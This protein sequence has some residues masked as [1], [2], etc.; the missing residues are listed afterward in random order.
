MPSSRL[1]VIACALA[2]LVL[3]ACGSSNRSTSSAPA[4][5]STGSPSSVDAPTG[6]AIRVG[7]ICSCTGPQTSNLSGAEKV[8]QAWADNV[9]LSGGINGHPVKL[10]AVDD[11]ANPATGLQDAKAL[12]EQDRVI[13]IV[14]ENS[15][16]DATWVPWVVK[17]GI[18]VV[19]GQSAEP[20]Q[21]TNPGVFPSGSTLLGAAIGDPAQAQAQGKHNLGVMYCAETPVC[22]QIV[23]LMTGIAKLFGLKV[24]P[25]SIS[26]TAPNYTAPC[27]KMQSAGVDALLVVDNGPIVQRVVAD[28][29]QQGYNPLNVAGLP[30]T[31]STMLKDQHLAGTIGVGPTAN[32]FDASTPAVKEFQDALQKYY[33][34]LLTSNGFAYD[35]FGTWAGG[36]LFEAAAKAAN[37]GPSSTPADVK[38]GLYALKGETLGGLAPPLT[39]TKGKPYFAPCWFTA[40][41]ENGTLVSLNGNKQ[42]C[43]SAAQTA[44]LFKALHLG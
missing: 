31:N 2:A 25:A 38:K 28:C 8:A 22:E 26:A 44:A 41:I 18:P 13:A 40:K 3:S 16:A 33:P 15:D 34:G 17:Q 23:P 29:A 12:V 39:Y 4:A 32:P 5:G 24:T 30:A 42:T 6:A 10:F 19:G 21:G 11:G 37:L 1:T 27:L 20:V 7:F 36:K 43:L 14:G 9:N 35:D